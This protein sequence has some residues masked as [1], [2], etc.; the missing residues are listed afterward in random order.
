[1]IIAALKGLIVSDD[2]PT[3][4][5]M[6]PSLLHAVMWACMF[7]AVDAFIA[8]K[9]I[10]GTIALAFSL[11]SHNIGIKWPWIKPKISP[12]FASLVER[13]ASNRLYR[14]AIYSAI[15]IVL[16]ASIGAAIYRYY[17]KGAIA[18]VPQSAPPS[19]PPAIPI[20]F[21][22][23]CEIDHIPIHI[24]AA[25]T[26]HVLRLHPAVLYGNP[27]I[28]DLGVFENISPPSEK[29]MDWPTKMNGR[30]MTNKEWSSGSPSTP[31][32]S[33]CTLTS[34]SPQ[35]TLDEIIA[36]LV[37]DIPDTTKPKSTPLAVKRLSFPIAFDPLT[38]GHPFKFYVVNTCSSGVIPVFVQWGD[39]AT[40]RVLGEPGP[41]TVPLRYERLNFPSQL[42][43]GSSMGKSEFI[44]NDLHDCQ[45]DRPK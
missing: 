38:F 27:R 22:L 31:F 21:R 1:M 2:A 41:R 13:I 44:W 3:P 9:W 30:W 42:L 33:N 43:M 39:S 18:E 16:F 20:S 17:H 24:P 32:A 34:Y 37:V 8:G 4:E 15:A 12:H 19:T 10:V 40:I 6:V 7:G 36:Y 35:V 29:P 14:Y 26:I 45:W 23:G 11:I 28:P 5:Q 25:S